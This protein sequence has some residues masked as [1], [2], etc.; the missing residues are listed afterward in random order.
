M[1][2]RCI[3]FH[4]RAV[5][6]QDHARAATNC[7]L[8]DPFDNLLKKRVD[9]AL[10]PYF[11]APSDALAA[12]CEANGLF[13]GSLALSVV[14][15]FVHW[16][17]GDLDAIVPGGGFEQFCGYLQEREGYLCEDDL[18]QLLHQP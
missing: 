15:G 7:A 8:A 1:A 2:T 18:E 5:S 16:V 9:D 6:L 17:P 3:P 4:L 14:L 12:L 11:Q 13:T 10:S